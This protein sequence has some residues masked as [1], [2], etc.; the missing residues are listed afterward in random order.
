MI[1][2]AE[3]HYAAIGRVAVESCTLD[4]EV[5]EYLTRLGSAPPGRSMIGHKLSLFERVLSSQ[6]LSGSAFSEFTSALRRVQHLIRCRNALSHGVWLPDPNSRFAA[7]TARS[8]RVSIHASEIADVA[9]KLHVARKVLLR[10]CQD[11]LPLAAGQKKR[12]RISV[13]KLL[14]RL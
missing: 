10:L 1:Q 7:S 12:I 4:R 5:S 9:A 3:Q 11:Y 2:L 6:S 8:E 13:A 14:L